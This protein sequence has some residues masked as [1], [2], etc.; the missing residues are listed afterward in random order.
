MSQRQS[1]EYQLFPI[2]LD[3]ISILQKFYDV[4]FECHCL[5]W[6]VQNFDPIIFRAGL[7][8]RQT[9]QSA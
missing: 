1:V 7:I 2:I 4:Y 5:N 3:T 9:R 6:K 8:K